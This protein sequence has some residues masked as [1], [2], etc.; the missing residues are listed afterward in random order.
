MRKSIIATHYADAADILTDGVRELI[1]Y[2]RTHQAHT[3]EEADAYADLADRLTVLVG[4]NTTRDTAS[5][6]GPER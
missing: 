6:K 3:S 4:P 2:C 5:R 1:D